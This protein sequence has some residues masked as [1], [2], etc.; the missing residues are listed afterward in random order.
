MS[1]FELEKGW[2]P[3]MPR[4]AV[5][6][7]SVSIHLSAEAFR[8]MMA[9]AEAKAE[10][11][12]AKAVIYNK[13]RWDKCHKKP[14]IKI[15]DLVLISTLNFNNL[16]GNRKL[17]DSFVGPF[18]VQKFHGNNAVEVVLTGE[19]SQ[20]HPT[21]LISL[22]KKFITNGAIK[23][24]IVVYEQQKEPI[25]V[26]VDKQKIPSKVLDEKIV[27]IQ[28]QDRRQYLVRFK[29]ASTDE[30]KWLFKE[31]IKNVE[32]LLQRFRARKRTMNVTP[33]RV[34]LFRGGKCQPPASTASKAQKANSD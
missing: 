33:V 26:I 29:N 13:E 28:G 12:V 34:I 15:G 25:P 10:E 8:I 21:F 16:G 3:F 17:K 11:C 1:P 30:D 14:D 32:P 18:V 5:M 20:K 23:T 7:K 4:D 2:V 9:S 19:F 22:V 6:S 24:Y 31:Q 27:R